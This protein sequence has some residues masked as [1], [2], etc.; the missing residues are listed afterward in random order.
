LRPWAWLIER[1]EQQAGKGLDELV[2]GVLIHLAR[3]LQFLAP[4]IQGR[5]VRAECDTDRLIEVL[6][7]ALMVG[8]VTAFATEPIGGKA[9][10]IR[11]YAWG[12]VPLEHHDA[13]RSIGDGIFAVRAGSFRD[14][15]LDRWLA[16]APLFV[17]EKQVNEWFKLRAPSSAALRAT[18]VQVMAGHNQASPGQPMRRQD[19]LGAVRAKHA[20]VSDRQLK[21][22]WK[23]TAPEEWKRPGT[24][25]GSRSGRDRQ[26]DR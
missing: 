8:R 16:N 3:D 7:A 25:G 23:E 1:I 2:Q 17:G 20:T 4:N 10:E 9:F 11:K 24:K 26:S 5:Y 18:A 21:A 6:R 13:E 12:P 15:S 19:F 22:L 14:G